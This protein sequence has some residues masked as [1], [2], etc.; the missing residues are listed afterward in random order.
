MNRRSFFQSVVAGIAALVGLNYIPKA[1]GD[2][3]ED[4]IWYVTTMD[5]KF[6]G[7]LIQYRHKRYS[8][9][10]IIVDWIRCIQKD[11]YHEKNKNG[12]SVETNNSEPKP[13]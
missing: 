5:D 11:Y 3:Y 2:C 7:E 4:D 13:V 9:D 8:D 6:K 10:E 12:N 1:K